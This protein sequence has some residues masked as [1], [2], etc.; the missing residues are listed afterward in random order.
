M[1]LAHITKSPPNPSHF[2]VLVRA[3]PKSKNE[4]FGDIIRN[5]F[6]NYHGSS[7][8]SHQMIYRS[9]KVQL[10]MVSLTLGQ[11]SAEKFIT[12]KLTLIWLFLDN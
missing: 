7:Y 1:R 10:I 6:V 5:F 3:I 2:S 11:Y 8:L 12:D 4:Q 9:G